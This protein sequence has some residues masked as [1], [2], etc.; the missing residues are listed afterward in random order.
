MK[1][2][3]TNRIK[4]AIFD[5]DNTIFYETINKDIFEVISVYQKK[6]IK[7]AIASYNPYVKWFC[8]R[9]GITKHFDIILGYH[10]EKNGKN[11]HIKEIRN[12]YAECGLIFHDNEIIFF[13]DDTNNIDNV[14]KETNIICIPV[15]P[16]T[17]ITLDILKL[18]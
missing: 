15:N 17:G 5:F 18:V 3:N 7:L 12:Y 9:Y 10:N 11:E 14:K 6:N 2:T 8:N 13:D 16:N 1:K 4:L